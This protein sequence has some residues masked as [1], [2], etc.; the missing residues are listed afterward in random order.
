MIFSVCMFLPGRYQSWLWD[1]IVLVMVWVFISELLIQPFRSHRWGFSFKS[2]HT[3][4]RIALLALIILLVIPLAHLS[5]AVS[6]D[7]TTEFLLLSHAPKW[8]N[9]EYGFSLSVDKARSVFLRDCLAVFMFL[10]V[11]LGVCTR[12]RAKSLLWLIVFLGTLHA[13]IG[14]LAKFSGQFLFDVKHIDGH[15]SAARGLF[16]NRNHFGWYL[17]LSSASSIALCYYALQRARQQVLVTKLLA[18][19]F[20]VYGLCLFALGLS[21]FAVLLSESR[22]AY[23]ALVFIFLFLGGVTQFVAGSSPSKQWPRRMLTLIL[24]VVLIALLGLLISDGLFQRISATSFSIGERSVQWEITF[25]AIMKQPI[26]GYGVGSYST[27]FQYYRGD[28]ELRNVIFDQSHN[29]YLHL[30]LEQGLIALIAWLTILVATCLI[31]W[32]RMIASSSNLTKSIMLSVLIVLLI[33]VL[34]SMVDFGTQIV[35][36][37]LLGFVTMALTFANFNRTDVRYRKSVF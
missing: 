11:S 8:F 17:I 29:E 6:N 32:R 34:L 25:S 13:G 16:I 18:V 31:T 37:R 33:T 26:L 21:I 7:F 28:N 5:S 10:Y 23:A 19:L 1:P 36:I 24:V 4:N 30:W 2:K 9:P 22:A 35:R 3:S 12:T 15:F 14:L 20:S 27:V